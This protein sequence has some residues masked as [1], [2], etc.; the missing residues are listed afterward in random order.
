MHFFYVG[1]KALGNITLGTKND[2][3]F[4]EYGASW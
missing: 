2:T 3:I 1:A 4:N